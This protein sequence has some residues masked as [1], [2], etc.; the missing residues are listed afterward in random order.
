MIMKSALLIASA[1]LLMS[2]PCLAATFVME[3]N[4]SDFSIDGNGGAIQGQ[5]LYLWNTNLTNVNQQWVQISHGDGYYSYKKQGTNLCWD[6][7]SGGINVQPVTL[8]V[9]D[10]GNFDQHWE[11]VKVF[12]GTEIYRFQKRNASGY[13][14]DGNNGASRRQS[15]YLWSSSNSN[16][17]QQWDL[18]RTDTS[19]NGNNHA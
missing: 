1:S 6:G 14:I 9:C 8:E 3:K 17:N 2:S 13:S 16:I 10:S 7:G 4:G 11:K 5:Q 19:D 15:I 12:S 18:T